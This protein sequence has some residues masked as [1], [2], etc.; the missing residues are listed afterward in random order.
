MDVKLIFQVTSSLPSSS[1]LLKLLNI[2]HLT[3]AA[4]RSNEK[5]LESKDSEKWIDK[6]FEG[7]LR[8]I[9]EGEKH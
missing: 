2:T 9:P 5:F 6:R 3:T 8:R 7:K 4:E 1:S